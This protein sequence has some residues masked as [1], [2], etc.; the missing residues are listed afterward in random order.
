M[1]AEIIIQMQ[2]QH[3]YAVPQHTQQKN[4]GKKK[5]TIQ[6]GDVQQDTAVCLTGRG[7]KEK[8]RPKE[9]DTLPTYHPNMQYN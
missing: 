5:V 7:M 6:A 1:D 4:N 3:Q 9:N 8:T 2:L